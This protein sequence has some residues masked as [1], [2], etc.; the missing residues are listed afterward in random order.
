MHEILI[1]DDGNI[2]YAAEALGRGEAVVF[3]TETVYGVGVDAR[4]N[5][6]VAGLYDYKGRPKLKPLS[7]CYRSFEE[8]LEDVES[9]SK[10]LLLAEKFLPGPVTIIMKRRAD[11]RISLLCSAGTDTVGIRVPSDPVASA[12]LSKLSF[13][14]AAPSANKSGTASPVTAQEA[15]DSLGDDKKLIILDGGRCSLGVEST[16]VDLPGNR[17]LRIGAADP[18]E[19]ERILFV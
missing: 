14:L 9:D 5:A 15:S 6:A 8:A 19:I 16:V 18:K 13:P 12:L 2:K 11:S 3:P 7:V 4:N 1:P 10:A 17:I